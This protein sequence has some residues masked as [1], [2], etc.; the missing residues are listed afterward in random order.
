MTKTRQTRQTRKQDSFIPGVDPGGNEDLAV[1][2]RLED[3]RRQQAR[4]D[5]FTQWENELADWID[6]HASNSVEADA[7]FVAY[8]AAREFRSPGKL[9][10]GVR[11]LI[12]GGEFDGTERPDWRTT[13]VTV[14]RLIQTFIQANT[15]RYRS[16]SLSAVF[17]AIYPPQWKHA[18]GTPRV[19]SRLADRIKRANNGS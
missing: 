2:Q 19:K 15:E 6:E 18:D 8:D 13:D 12:F 1:I 10:G 11:W 3:K 14:L 9:L 16:M 4:A 5:E 7:F 17:D